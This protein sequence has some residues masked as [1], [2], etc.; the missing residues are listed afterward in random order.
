MRK[1]AIF[2]IKGGVGKTTTAINLAA[3]LAR[4]GKKV[5]LLDM[6]PQGSVRNCLECDEPIK[7]MFHLIANGAELRECVLHIGKDLE[8]VTSGETLNDIDDTLQGRANKEFILSIKLENLTGY[9]YI[10]MDCPPNYGTLT[11]NAL[12]FADEVH[13]PTSTD[14][15]G[16]K[17]VLQ[18][19]ELIDNFNKEL[20]K[21]D[22]IT[23]SK[24]IPT[25]YDKRLKVSRET[26]ER[27]QQDFYSI[28]SEPIRANSKLKE[29]P[30]KKRS[31]FA[32]AKGSSGAKD[33]GAFVMEVMHAENQKAVEMSSAAAPQIARA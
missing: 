18:T 12:V 13:I 19:K 6:D 11:K 28:V 21:E 32:Y 27:L 16:H 9:D 20:Q 15:L 1:I 5:L 7:D 30:S 22:K 10:I 14:V 3:G 25:L 24:I 29:A 26:V 17:G 8:V 31:I 33:Y 2:N 4:K 23:I